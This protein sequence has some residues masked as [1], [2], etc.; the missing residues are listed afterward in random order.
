MSAAFLK[1]IRGPAS[2]AVDLRA[3]LAE[4]GDCSNAEEIAAAEAQRREA[5]VSGSDAD[6]ERAEQARATALRNRDRLAARREEL[7]KRLSQ[8][9]AREAAEALTAE[10]ATAEKKAIESVKFL[11]KYPAL[12]DELIAGLT[13][14]LA[15][16]QA[17]G[18]IN[19][20][21]AEAGREDE[22]LEAV[23]QRVVPMPQYT[24]N[25]SLISGVVLPKREG[26]SQGWNG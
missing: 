23:E 20:K 19:T 24:I 25:R 14:L 18:A 21:L 26:Y 22:N 4:L 15:A 9:E 16:E 2:S 10:R 1:L 6:V 13:S 5:L 17:V 11:K 8:A 12:A 3:A 7:E